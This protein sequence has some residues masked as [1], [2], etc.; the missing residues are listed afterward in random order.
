MTHTPGPWVVEDGHI[1]RDSGGI[2]YWQISDGQDSIACNQFCYAG[3]NPAVN[4]A[5]A[6][7]I[8][9]APSLLEALEALVGSFEKHRPKAYWDAARAAIALARGEAGK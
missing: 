1:Q 5:N 8:A 4:A 7:L 9:A 3:Q 2:R 6:R